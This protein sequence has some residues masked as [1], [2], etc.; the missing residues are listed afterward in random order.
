MKKK[1]IFASVL[2]AAI[3]VFSCQGPAAPKNGPDEL[4][5]T[6]YNTN[7]SIRVRN[8]TGERL[9][10]FK[11][12]LEPKALAGGIPAYAMDH[13][14]PNNTALFNDTGDFPLVLLTEAQYNDKKN[15][16]GSLRYTPFTRVYVFFN[17]NG[18][19]KTVY[20]IAPGLGGTNS[21]EIINTS[22]SVNVELRLNGVVGRTLGYA[23]A[24]I[25][26]TTL[27][28]EDGEYDIFPVFKRYNKARDLVETVFPKGTGS[29]YAWFKSYSF[30]KNT[31][32]QT[33]NLKELLQS[34]TFTPGAAWVY[35]N[36]KSDSGIKFIA[37]TTL[38]TASGRE[39]IGSGEPVT[40]QIDMPRVGDNFMD[41]M[42]VANWKF[43]PSG[44]GVAL[45]ESETDNTPV[46]SL[47]IY[48]GKMYTV[49]VSG[50]HNDR[51]LKAW[52]SDTT[53]V[54]PGEL[55]GTW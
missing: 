51:T 38:L 36:N 25:L 27:K 49:T 17:K 7:Y 32:S 14:L 37:G 11:G 2:A 42:I 33:L 5:F 45:Q 31:T 53:D 4:D 6:N 47:T 35:V 24:G 15:D 34:T 9:V 3:L 19:N 12:E 39:N 16:L 10:A 20:E 48:R 29:N 8:N 55:V 44:F 23:P 30:G 22:V 41:S 28:L 50:S 21:L 1:M 26:N 40:F 52:I 54:P 43:G 13:G 46:A 18:E